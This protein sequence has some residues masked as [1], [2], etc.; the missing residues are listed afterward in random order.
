MR[1]TQKQ[2]ASALEDAIDKI[3]HVTDVLREDAEKAGGKARTELAVL[4]EQ[5]AEARRTVVAAAEPYRAPERYR[6]YVQFGLLL[7]VLA[8]V[9][10]IVVRR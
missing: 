8:A 5:L 10:A 3:E 1:R 6:R 9:A 7:A 2:V 4:P